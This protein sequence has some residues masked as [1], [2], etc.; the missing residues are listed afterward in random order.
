MGLIGTDRHRYKDGSRADKE[1][2]LPVTDMMF[3]GRNFYT[4]LKLFYRTVKDW[5]GW[6]LYHKFTHGCQTVDEGQGCF[7]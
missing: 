2:R 5:N 1:C 6:I 7:V 3:R 4:L